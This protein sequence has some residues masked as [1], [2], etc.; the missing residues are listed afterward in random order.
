MRPASV[1]SDASPIP[2]ERLL[3]G[4]S[5]AWEDFLARYNSEI[6]SVVAWR[7]WNLPAS[8]QEEICQH[9]RGELPRA[10][11]RYQGEASLKTFLR[12][13][14]INQCIDHIRH[15]AP[16][17]DITVELHLLT[18]EHGDMIAH[19]PEDP[20]EGVDDKI[21]RAELAGEARKAL[22]VLGGDCEGMLEDLYLKGLKY[23]EIGLKRGMTIGAVCGKISRCLGHFKKICARNVV[24]SEYLN[25]T[26]DDGGEAL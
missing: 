8:L 4:D 11:K 1:M 12:R 21:A 24:L 19:E 5:V 14:C 22:S 26:S 25:L 16:R 10:L 9:I 13:I 23:K 20:G 15:R 17:R 6:V 18:D 3:S 2:L 7:K